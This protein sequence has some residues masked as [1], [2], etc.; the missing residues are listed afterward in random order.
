MRHS[1]DQDAQPALPSLWMWITLAGLVIAVIVVAAYK[2]WPILYPTVTQMASPDLEC[3]LRSDSCSARFSAGGV[4]R[5]S[6]E[7]RE[8]PLATPLR[9][10]VEIEGLDARRVQIDFAGADMD[11]GFNRVTLE[12]S[13]PGRFDGQG[14]LPVCVR[15]R[16]IWE[17]RA[18]IETPEGI[19][20]APF[21]FETW[22]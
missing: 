6:I 8:I 12:Q 18:L 11:M 1:A 4:I 3:D 5:F 15:A 17:A 13:R 22:R 2:A 9:F 16:M 21:R 19:W 20:A 7:P 10:T 14:M